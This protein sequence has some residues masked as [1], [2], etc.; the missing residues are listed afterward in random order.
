MSIQKT[1]FINGVQDIDIFTCY[2]NVHI[3]VTISLKNIFYQSHFRENLK[4][5][6]FSVKS[7]QEKN[8]CGEPEYVLLFSLF[9][10]ILTEFSFPFQ[11]SLRVSDLNVESNNNRLQVEDPMIIRLFL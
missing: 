4:Q 11:R 9:L 6:L 7:R 2:I 10:P 8:S 1:F 3:D 5:A